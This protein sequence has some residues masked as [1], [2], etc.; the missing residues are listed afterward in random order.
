MKDIEKC[1]HFVLFI[2]LWNVVLT[3]KYVNETLL[4]DHS[5]E[6]YREVLSLFIMLWNV[7]LTFESV[8]VTIKMN[9][10]QLTT[11]S[12]VCFSNLS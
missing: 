9:T 7:V 12:F 5:N 11:V 1:F 10:V 6:R 8:N 2:M 4:C 3:F